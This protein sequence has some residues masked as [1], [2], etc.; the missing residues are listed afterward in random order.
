[1]TPWKVSAPRLPIS[2]AAVPSQLVD[3]C[4][5]GAGSSLPGSGVSLDSSFPLSPPQAASKKKEKIFFGDTPNPGRG[6]AALCTP[7]ERHPPVKGALTIS[8][9]VLE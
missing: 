1:M 8:G 3:A 2:S 4:E 9:F 6:L 7:A 5:R